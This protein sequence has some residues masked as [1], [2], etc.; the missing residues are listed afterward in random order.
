M[1]VKSTE[2]LE[3]YPASS[4]TQVET[5]LEENRAP[6]LPIIVDFDPGDKENPHNWSMLRKLVVANICVLLT[7]NSTLGS[8]MPAGSIKFIAEDFNVT[9]E[10]Q[11]VLPISVFLIGYIVGPL[12]LAPLSE[13]Y[14][15]KPLLF[16]TF[17]LYLCFTLGTA[18]APNF[19]A[20][21]VLRFLAGTAA[22]APLGIV[23]GL[24]AD[25]FPDPV[26]RGRVMALWA[27]GTTFGPTLSPVIS[28]FLGQVS[29]RWPFWFELIFGGVSLIAMLFLPET[30]RPV[31]LAKRAAR[32][33]K[34]L[35][36]D[37]IVVPDS[38][39]TR[40]LKDLFA[41][42]LTRPVTMLFT[43]PIVPAVCLYMAFLYAILYL[44]FQAYPIIFQGEYAM[45]PGIDGLAYMPVGIGSVISAIMV[46]LWDEH[47]P[48]QGEKKPT[49]EYHRLTLA[50]IGGPL[51]MIS[52][53]WL[54]GTP[55]WEMSHLL[56][57]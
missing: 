20:L 51:T 19:P 39:E 33:K 31:I 44:F 53:F 34:E 37:D 22:A 25:C 57:D 11:L 43:E 1:V 50:I 56:S 27:A 26:H 14:G 5:P 54:V 47:M 23:G 36:R 4:E 7:L 35:N 8:S 46:V 3:K 29:W 48:R 24:F 15:R 30:F 9:N 55:G 6:Q 16:W 17:V 18:L 40:N 13:V 38:V 21:L 42:T 52:F 2:I 49:M 12:F 45:A 28:G 41:V 32:M 10:Y